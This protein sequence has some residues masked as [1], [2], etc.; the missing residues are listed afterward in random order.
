VIL[1]WNTN[2]R[3]EALKTLLEMDK[4]NFF[5]EDD[6]A[7]TLKFSE[8]SMV[9]WCKLF[10]HHLEVK[11]SGTATMLQMICDI[12]D[13]SKLTLARKVVAW[14]N[15]AESRLEDETIAALSSDAVQGTEN[16]EIFLM[17]NDLLEGVRDIWDIAAQL[18]QVP[19]A[20]AMADLLGFTPEDE[21]MI[22]Q[23]WP[24]FLAYFYS[25]QTCEHL[26]DPHPPPLTSA[27]A[28]LKQDCLLWPEV[29]R[30]ATIAKYGL[31][32]VDILPPV[33][34][35]DLAEVS[36]FVVDMYTRRA[37]EEDAELAAA[38][39][40]Q[41][42][43]HT[44]VKM[45]E[46]RSLVHKLSARLQTAVRICQQGNTRVRVFAKLAGMTKTPLEDF[47][48][49][50][51]RFAMTFWRLLIEMD[52]DGSMS[53]RDLA[54][55]LSGEQHAPSTDKHFANHAAKASTMGRGDRA[56]AAGQVAKACVAAAQKHLIIPPETAQ[57]FGQL[58]SVAD[59]CTLLRPA[60]V[61]ANRGSPLPLKDLEKQVGET[62][63][64]D[65][66]ENAAASEASASVS[67]DLATGIAL[68]L[69]YR[70]LRQ[71]QAH[72]AELWGAHE[73]AW[74]SGRNLSSPDLSQLRLFLA[75][76]C[77]LAFDE[78]HLTQLFL[79][80]SS[81]DDTIDMQH[82]VDCIARHLHQARAL[83]VQ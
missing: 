65:C 40:P 55:W 68:D 31:F 35:M 28:R 43:R 76:A 81:Y 46:P 62:A 24:S 78:E 74:E 47:Y 26:L 10:I 4:V 73:Q 59:V 75:Q 52:T 66:L 70:L 50:A 16:S 19:K 5:L 48:P 15:S 36:V 63:T 34:P 61:A 32:D 42:L 49:C 33:Q 1:R 14:Y 53:L 41:Y 3:V 6:F 29:E 20:N 77:N 64:Q 2:Q 17:R 9:R 11:Y 57:A 21:E 67:F 60:H 23:H 79:D 8:P 25:K 44:M 38:N 30:R 37:R 83:R 13:A 71:Y 54:R 56:V 12:F 80:M 51:E 45:R 18:L 69:W 22:S 58:P 39:L 27:W 82:G 7:A 72:V